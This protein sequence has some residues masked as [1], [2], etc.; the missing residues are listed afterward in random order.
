[1][2]RGDVL[3]HTPPARTITARVIHKLKKR[4]GVSAIALVYRL[5]KL[6]ILSDWHYRNLCIEL[7][8][9]GYRSGEA[10]GMDRDVSQVFAKVFKALKAEGVTRGAMARD[11]ALTSAEIDSLLVGLAI[12]SVS[13]PQGFVNKQSSIRRMTP[14]PTFRIV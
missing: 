2:P 14:K 4:W 11:L 8:S 10:D 6:E 13:Q 9:A 12:A 5:H 7:S 3:A 1:M